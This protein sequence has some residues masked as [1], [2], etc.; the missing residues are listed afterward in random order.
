MAKLLKHPVVASD[1]VARRASVALADLGLHEL[2]GI[3]TAR[4]LWALDMG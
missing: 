3:P 2:R 1:G 4:R